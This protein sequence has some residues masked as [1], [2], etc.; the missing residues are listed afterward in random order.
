MYKKVILLVLTLV[1]VGTGCTSFNETGSG[2]T[3]VKFVNENNQIQKRM[4]DGQKDLVKEYNQ[5]T[6][7]TNKGDITIEFYSD[8]SPVTVNNFLNLAE[9]GFY[10]GTT[11]HRVIKNF[12]IQG[13]DPN[14]KDQSKRFLHGTGDP[15]YKFHD[16]FNDEKLVRGSFAM[17]NSGP[18]TN[19]SQFFIVTAPVTPWLDGRHTNFGKVVSGME[20]VEM[21][22]D[23]S[24]DTADNPVDPIII[25]S[26]SLLP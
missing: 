15:G 21:I 22:E 18:G 6:L 11:F 24:V 12:M 8:K 2:S 20:V 10:N 3:K 14:S 9:S 13:G 23:V 5:A 4:L 16:E 25:E 1:L 7:K 19:G 17:A 26:I